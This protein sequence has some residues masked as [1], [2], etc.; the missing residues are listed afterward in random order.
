MLRCCI[1]LT[2]FEFEQGLWLEME[3]QTGSEELCRDVGLR[4]GRDSLNT[5]QVTSSEKG[6]DLHL[7]SVISVLQLEMGK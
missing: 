4:R 5:A 7:S 1:Y 3:N 2:W 6:R